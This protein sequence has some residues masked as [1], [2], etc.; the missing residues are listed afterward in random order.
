MVDKDSAKHLAAAFLRKSATKTRFLAKAI[1]SVE[2]EFK[3]I[4]DFHHP[5]WRTLRRKTKIPFG[6]RI[7]VDKQTGKAEHFATL[8]K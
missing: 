1:K 4:F 8:Q 5:Q 7:A 6:V 3:W 2:T